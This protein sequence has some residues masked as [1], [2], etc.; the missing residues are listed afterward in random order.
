MF[1][2]AELYIHQNRLLDIER[3]TRIAEFSGREGNINY[4]YARRH[5]RLKMFHAALDEEGSDV[6]AFVDSFP[7]LRN[8]YVSKSEE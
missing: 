4:Y 2:I 3:D 6:L 5:K 7:P 1:Y 8:E